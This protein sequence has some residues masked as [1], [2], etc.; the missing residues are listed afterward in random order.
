[1]T[2]TIFAS[3]C[4]GA[5]LLVLPLP[6]AAQADT[7]ADQGGALFVS[8]KCTLC[9][10]VAGKGNPKGPLDSAATTRKPDEIRLWIL[11]PE[12]MR[13][14]TKATRTPAMKKTPLSDDQ[15][16]ALV[17]Y[18]GSLKGTHAAGNR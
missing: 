13:E 10:S 15:V 2:R 17:A 3:V 4:A 11:D 1:M 5:L 14:K 16:D 7:K 8:K 6:A 9:H 18:L 12:A